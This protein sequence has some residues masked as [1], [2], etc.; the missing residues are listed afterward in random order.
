VTTKDHTLATVRINALARRGDA[1][2]ARQRIEGRDRPLVAGS[3]GTVVSTTMLGRPKKVFFAVSYGWGLKRFE[4]MVGRRDV[5]SA[6]R[7]AETSPT[8][9]LE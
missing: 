4:V 8:A 1:V 7:D 5:D 9:G 6:Q 3:R 2:I